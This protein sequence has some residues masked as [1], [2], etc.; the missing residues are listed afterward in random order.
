[1]HEVDYGEV[2]KRPWF[3]AGVQ[4]LLGLA[5]K[6]PT[7]ILCSEENPASCHRHH[8][9]ACYLGAEHPEV[10]VEHIRGDGTIVAA[11]SIPSIRPAFRQLPLF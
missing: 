5:S 6:E 1:L 7:A 10:D 3:I 4:R 8:L 2:M 9:I 11:R